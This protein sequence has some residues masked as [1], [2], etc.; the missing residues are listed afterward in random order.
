MKDKM[1]WKNRPG[2]KTGLIKESRRRG[3]AA[4]MIETYINPMEPRTSWGLVISL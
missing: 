1:P 4:G 3:R 2:L